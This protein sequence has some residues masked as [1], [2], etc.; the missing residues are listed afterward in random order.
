MRT[1]T[2]I[3]TNAARRF[4]ATHGRLL[5]RHRLDVVL[6][7]DTARDR[8]AAAVAG[9]RNPDGGF[10]WGLEPDLRAPESQ[11]GGALHALE[12]LAD[13]QRS[14]PGTVGLLDW[15]E[16]ASLPDGGLPFALLIADPAGC[17]PFWVAA[18]AAE[19]SLQITAV[20]A[21]HA[22]RLA[23]IDPAVAAHPWT[24]AATGFCFERIARLDD[25]PFAYVL[26]FVLQLLD[27]THD[28]HPAAPELLRRTARF[29]PPDGVLRMDDGESIHPLDYAPEPDRPVR[30]ILEPDAV[31]ADLARLA[32][33][34][35]ADGGWT[36]DFPSYSSAA[37]LEWRGY[38]TVSAVRTL[39]A[40]A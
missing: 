21:A 19:S 5:D 28:T 16:R 6:G 17:A 26:S 13:A 22:H 36:V 32:G 8:V 10:G 27:A 25:A 38:T 31:R 40:N 34:Q 15:L 2:L 20:V 33:G 1:E 14:G 23:R 39:R 4:L 29:V 30:G 35:Q 12:A 9:Y 24:A 3:D 18:D 11:P 37:A 7:D